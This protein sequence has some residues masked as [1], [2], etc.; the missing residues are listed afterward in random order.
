MLHTLPKLVAKRKKR[1][2]QGWSSGKGKYTGRGCKGQKARGDIH[3]NFTGGQMLMS[4][5]LPMLRGKLKNKPYRR[6]IAISLQTLESTKQF[7]DGSRVTMASL[8][9]A[10]IMRT[11]EARTSVARLVSQGT[12]TKKLTVEIGAS[13]KAIEKIQHAGGGITY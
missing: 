3:P 13:K 7:K 4:K 12:I 10:G 8:I 2:G 5:G 1:L 11:S 9:K 6:V